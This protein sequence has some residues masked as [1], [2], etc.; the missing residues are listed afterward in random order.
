MVRRRT[1]LTGLGLVVALVAGGGCDCEHG[2][3]G[4]DPEPEPEPPIEEPA[5][6]SSAMAILQGDARFV[7]FVDYVERSAFADEL[8][9]PPARTVF[10]P[11]NDAIGT[12]SNA[13]IN[14]LR[15]DQAA[16]GRFVRHHIG[17]GLGALTRDQ[18]V[19]LA[20]A[21]VPVASGEVVAVQQA[22]DGTITIGGVEAG[23]VLN[24]PEG[25]VVP[26]ES[27]ALLPPDL[28]LVE[29]EPAG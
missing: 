14:A 13:C 3:M 28:G 15:G 16:L 4:G 7:A 18:L 29:C 23:E 19:G 6:E 26:L 9:S 1:T 22:G 17:R 10:A 27:G 20:G 5:P 21:S 24:R 12:L 2:H 8:R 25:A 11:T